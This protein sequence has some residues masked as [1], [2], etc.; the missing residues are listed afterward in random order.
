M[1]EPVAG[2]TGTAPDTNAP[3]TQPVAEVAVKE[4]TQADMDRVAGERGKRA[5]EAAIKE[6]LQELGI[7]KVDD[8][9]AVITDT[10]KK[11]DA[12]KSDLQKAQE[13][14][15]QL[16]NARVVAEKQ[17]S[18]LLIRS[19][20]LD[21]A[22]EANWLHPELAIKFADD[23]SEVK[24]TAGKVSGVDEILKAL[25]KQY[26][27]QVKRPDDTTSN[28]DATRRSD[29]T[30]VDPKAREEELKRRFNIR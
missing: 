5:K 24:V 9:K 4:F 13:K 21:A 14:N 3:V 16:E 11:Q 20:F 25:T 18:D 10:R 17:Y 6:L 27:D 29:K 26:P 7:E 1:A 19:A 15:T 12:E 22:G 23:L 2:T 8:L 28:V 30:K